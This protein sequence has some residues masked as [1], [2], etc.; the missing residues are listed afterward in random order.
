[1]KDRTNRRKFLR[2]T[3]TTTAGLAILPTIIPASA[4]GKNGFVAPSNRH[5]MGF[6]GVGSQ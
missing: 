4:M 6:I 3:L 2:N 5:V 1:M